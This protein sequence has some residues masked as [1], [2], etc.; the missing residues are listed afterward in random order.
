MVGHPVDLDRPPGRLEP[1]VRQHRH[2]VAVG[3]DRHVGTAEL[4]PQL[5]VGALHVDEEG[6]ERRG[7]LRVVLGERPAD[8]QRLARRPDGLPVEMGGPRRR[9]RIG[10]Q[11]TRVDPGALDGS[12]EPRH[13][14]VRPPGDTNPTG[15][16]VEPPPHPPGRGRAIEPLDQRVDPAPV[17]WGGRLDRNGIRLGWEEAV[18]DDR[19]AHQVEQIGGAAPGRPGA[20]GPCAHRAHGSRPESSVALGVACRQR[21]LDGVAHHVVQLEALGRE[22]HERQFP[23]PSPPRPGVAVD[24]V[25]CHEVGEVLLGDAPHRRHRLHHPHVGRRQAVQQ[26][27]DEPL[28]DD[29]QRTGVVTRQGPRHGCPEAQRQRVAPG[30][31]GDGLD[32]GLGHRERTEHRPCVGGRERPDGQVG[33]QPVPPRREQPRGGRAVAADEQ[34]GELLRHGREKLGPQPAVDESQ[35]LDPVEHQAP[36]GVG[37]GESVAH[38]GGVRRCPD[39]ATEGRE[40]ARRRWF[41]RAA[42]HHEGRAGL[43]RRGERLDQRGL[44][45]PG[46]PVDEDHRGRPAR[47]RPRAQARALALTADELVL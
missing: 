28:D 10:P 33:E 21:P 22:R 42:R 20:A 3:A 29:G 25:V 40:H 46:R 1:Q 38:G 7:R 5:E 47:R 11:Q 13:L 26:A 45:D 16:G 23:Q 32:R 19:V 44:A 30:E 37:R 14:A 31:A 17:P 35:A 15:M 27:V 34:R 6:A 12:E 4:R 9:H 39:E 2:V 18:T 8:E 41:H 36:G 24:V 43:S